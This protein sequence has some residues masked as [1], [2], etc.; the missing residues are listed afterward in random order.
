MLNKID[1]SL[2]RL[3]GTDASQ[4]SDEL[5]RRLGVSTA[6]VRRRIKKLMSEGILR[7]IGVVEPQKAGFPVG[8]LLSLDVPQD[9]L[10]D[11]SGEL[12]SLPEVKWLATVTGKAN[13][14]AYVRA[15][16][17]GGISEF[18]YKHL[19]NPDSIKSCETT[20]CL[21]VKK[22]SYTSY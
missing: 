8:A 3:L 16:S 21:D 18:L 12:C 14:V 1:E 7:I 11:I 9:K 19:S 22:G 6:V 17:A 5:S 15:E 2:V 13:I 4:S 20:L 10:E